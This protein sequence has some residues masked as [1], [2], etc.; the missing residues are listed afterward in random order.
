[1]V[2]LP[3]SLLVSEKEGQAGLGALSR[4]ITSHLDEVVG[5]HTQPDP[6]SH[7]LKAR[8][9]TAP[10]SVDFTIASQS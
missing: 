2:I 10:Q 9:E 6:A 7:A 3:A 5:N 4:K 8:V 1:M